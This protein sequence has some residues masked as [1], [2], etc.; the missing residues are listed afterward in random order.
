MKIV[1]IFES[2]SGEAGTMIR[3][4]SLCTFVRFFGCPIYCDYCD[5]PGSWQND[6][7]SLEYAPYQ[8]IDQIEAIGNPNVI[9]TGGA[10]FIQPDIEEFLTCLSDSDDIDNIVI[11]ASGIN[12]PFNIKSISEKITYAV[13]YKLPSAKSDFFALNTFPFNYLGYRDLIKFLIK[14]DE[15][16]SLAVEKCQSV[17]ENRNRNSPT[18]VFTP[19]NNKKAE[20]ILT[21]LKDAG[22]KAVINV[23][24]HKILN[25]A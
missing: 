24:I 6:A 5:T 13:D 21:V 15:D 14:T 4:G 18:F 10:P 20:K 23:Q 16:L 2:I 25:I 12:A 1:D 7:P 19:M 17:M 8:I 9:V 3:Q 22:I 11:E